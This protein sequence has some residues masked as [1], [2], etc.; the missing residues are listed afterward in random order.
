MFDKRDQQGE[1]FDTYLNLFRSLAKPCYFG[2]LRDNLLRDRIVLG[3]LDNTTRKKLLDEPKLPL[4]KCVNIC[5]AN[6]TTMKQLKEITSDEISAVTTLH[7]LTHSEATLAALCEITSHAIIKA[8]ARDSAT[9]ITLK[10]N[11]SSVLRLTQER[12]S[13]V[14]PGRNTVKIV[15]F[16]TTSWDRRYA[17][18]R[19]QKNQYME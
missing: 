2:E 4:D 10:S 5:R 13:Y 3:L 18:S 17:Q 16:L 15:V 12:K 19:Q 1:S 7:R 14:Q 9:W 8:A 6:E 11:A